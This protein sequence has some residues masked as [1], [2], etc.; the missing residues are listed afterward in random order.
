MRAGSTHSLGVD[1]GDVCQPLGQN[2]TRHLVAVLVSELS[3]LSSGSVYRG[4]CVC[5]GASHDTTN[6]WRE[7]VDVRDR[8]RVDELVLGEH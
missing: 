6:G 5:N 3:S 4:S 1:L 8:G 2:I 7:F